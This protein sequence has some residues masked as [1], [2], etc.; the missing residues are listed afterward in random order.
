MRRARVMASRV[1]RV[2]FICILTF[3]CGGAAAGQQGTCDFDISIAP[4]YGGVHLG[5]SVKELRKMFPG[6]DE[7]EDASPGVA[8]GAF[9]VSLGML[10]LNIRKE[11][12][13]GVGELS[14]GFAEGK[15]RRIGV[16]YNAPAPWESLTEFSEQVSKR[17]VLPPAWSA[18]RKEGARESRVL[19]CRGFLVVLRIDK[20]EAGYLGI[21]DTTIEKKPDAAPTARKQ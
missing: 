2:L 11:Q 3:A 5:M 19:E 17:L 7:L 10:E 14:L 8:G 12:F 15:L 20:G 16:H 9:N 21:V 1:G 13:K 18:P 6:S 4:D